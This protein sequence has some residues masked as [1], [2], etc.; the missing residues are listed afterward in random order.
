M[1]ENLSQTLNVP[2]GNK[3]SKFNRNDSRQTSLINKSYFKNNKNII[4]LKKGLMNLIYIDG[5]RYKT[6]DEVFNEIKI[7]ENK[8]NSDYGGYS[9][10]LINDLKKIREEQ[11]ETKKLMG[12]S[13]KKDLSLAFHKNYL[14]NL[15][16]IPK[17]HITRNKSIN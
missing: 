4:N 9:A 7:Q 2:F 15:I 14:N 17:K 10:S 11:K 1:M 12:E 16:K 13:D 6:L 5:K 8:F 3:S